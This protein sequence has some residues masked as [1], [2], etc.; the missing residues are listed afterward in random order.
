MKYIF[1]GGFLFMTVL[2]VFALSWTPPK[3]D[4]RIELVWCTGD[5]PVF[6]RHIELFNSQC[7][8]YRVVLDPFNGGLEKVIVQSLAGVGPDLFDVHTSAALAA[9]VRSGIAMD[10]T[11]QLTALGIHRE[12]LWPC[13]EPLYVFEGRMYGFPPNT[14]A[15][16]IWFNKDH[17]DEAGIP[18]PT[19]GW[20]WSEFIDIAKRLNRYDDQG[21][22]I[23]FGFI[24]PWDPM[25]WH[26]LLKQWGAR[27]YNAQGTRCTL[28]SPEAAEAMQFGRDLIHKYHIMPTPTDEA[29]LS[30][31]GGWGSGAMTW[32]GDGRGSMA[33]G[34][35]WWL[36]RLRDPAFGYLRLGAVP[37]PTGPIDTNMGSGRATILNAHSRHVEGAL[38]FLAFMNTRQYSDF[39]NYEADGLP[40]VKAHSYGPDF[41]YNP[42]Y[43][44]EDFHEVWRTA[45]ENAEPM[46]TTSFANGA[47]VERIMEAQTDLLKLG[48]KSGDEAMR[49][50]ARQI[51][52]S[53]IEMVRLDPELRK[54]YQKAIEKGAQPAW[55]SPDQAPW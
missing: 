4:E 13:L 1:A 36:I 18:Y 12:D 39:I 50:A 9:C 52:E 42:D 23:R 8:N 16:A 14:H 34:G 22:P 55:D 15:P 35:R 21:R 47:R 48:R 27:F 40:P 32:F 7:K 49:D 41:G 26:P 54:R 53:I 37:L 25:L 29:G 24:G 17:F 33:V 30:T 3:P 11:D 43:P 45:I 38:E 31:A 5:S 19:A 44:N 28:D 2:T 10:C 46:E 6:R 51:N 20:T